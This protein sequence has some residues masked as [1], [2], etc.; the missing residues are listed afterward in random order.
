MSKKQATLQVEERLLR[1]AERVAFDR[2]LTLD[3]LFEQALGH[4]VQ[5]PQARERHFG[6]LPTHGHGGVL[7][8]VDLDDKVLIDRLVDW[9]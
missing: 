2:K 5:T 4:V 9:P 6:K 1:E 8:G 7:P 3:Q